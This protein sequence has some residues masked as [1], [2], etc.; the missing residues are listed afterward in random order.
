MVKCQQELHTQG[1]LG[2]PT[3]KYPEDSSL[4]NVEAMQWVLLYPSIGHDIDEN[5]VNV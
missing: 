4:V 3:G 5:S 2:V 1:C